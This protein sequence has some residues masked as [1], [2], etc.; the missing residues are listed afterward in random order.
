[1]DSTRRL[2]DSAE[3]LALTLAQGGMQKTTARVMAAL[4]YTQQEAMTAS[5]LCEQL[6]V[7]AGAVSAAIKQLTQSGMV[8]R[9]PA[10]GSRREHYRF[11]H[12]VWAYLFSQQNL[13]LKAM[14]EAAQEGLAAAPEDSST[15]A[16]LHE[17]REFYAYMERELP[18][19]IEQWRS[20]YH[21]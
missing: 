6:S 8:E 11:P 12:G 15:A 20:E 2:R 1:M 19:L 21:G 18:P 13:M 14:R 17:M 9:V 7:S 5:D 3:R 10:P 4:L 16:R